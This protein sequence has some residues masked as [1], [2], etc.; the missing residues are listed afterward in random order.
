VERL[1]L[2]KEVKVDLNL[3]GKVAIV[4]GAARGMGLATAL[5]FAREGANVVIDDIDLEAAK[6][7]EEGAKA[8]GAQ[9]IAVRADVTKP[10]EVRQMV[11]ETLAKFGRL[12][13]LVNNAGILYID[14]KPADRK[15]F[16]DTSEDEWPAEIDVTLY[17]VLNCA[18]AAVEPMLRQKSGS[19]INIASDA[20]RGAM[21]RGTVYG[22]GK[23]GTIAF[24][25]HLA[26][27]L[28]PSGIRVNCVSPGVI[29]TTRIEAIESGA[30]LSPE[31]AEAHKVLEQLAQKSPLGRIGNPQ[32]I[33]NVVV[34]LASDA[35]SYVT[36]QT[37][38]VN[39]GDLMP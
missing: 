4:T 15:F 5:T 9:A 14:G 1:E 34:F 38:S 27:E 33:A 28:G 25:R 19:I 20:G 37:I 12:D 22:A 29:K 23:G 32:E 21:P 16:K 30:K 36:G 3:G 2:I 17:G 35:S 13:I 39:G 10:D 26:L 11:N 7:V 8:L 18:R 31:A 24:T 6:L